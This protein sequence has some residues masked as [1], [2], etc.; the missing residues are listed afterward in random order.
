MA[1]RYLIALGSNRRHPCH[2]SPRRV[3]IAA[4]AA[5]EA[6]GIA[7]LAM[8][9][10]ID[11]APVGPSLRRY[12]NGAALVEC[13]FA[14]DQLLAVLKAIECQFG[15]R[16][17]GQRWTSRVLDLDIVL[18]S[19]GAWTSPGLTVP[20]PLFRTRDF[21]LGPARAIAPQWRDPVTGLTLR[22]LHARLTRPRT[23]PR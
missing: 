14:P 6:R 9:P 7:V 13:R 4:L 15:R 23:I 1:Q 22:Q 12:A 16:S 19:G 21:V 8:A 11:S 5:L 17:G 10:V 2:G 20:H 18:W 3:L